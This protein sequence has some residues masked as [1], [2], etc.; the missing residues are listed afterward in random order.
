[1]TKLI[2]KN[3]Y[4]LTTTSYY[5]WDEGFKAGQKSTLAPVSVT[6]R[7]WSWGGRVSF[8]RNDDYKEYQKVIDKYPQEGLWVSE[9]ETREF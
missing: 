6:G 8:V 4:A 9:E 2:T 3:P 1:M 7:W 5:V